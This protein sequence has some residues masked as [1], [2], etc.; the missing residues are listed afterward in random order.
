MIIFMSSSLEHKITTCTLCPR[1]VRWRQ[2]IGRIKVPRFQGD[3]YWAKPVAGFGSL[4]AECL[5]VGLAPA[6]HGANRTGRMFTGDRSGEWLYRALAK[7]GFANQAESHHR[8][9]GLKLHN[10]FITAVLHCAPPQNKPAKDEIT[11]CRR[12]FSSEFRQLKRLR[13][14]ICLGQ[15][16][17]KETLCL[18]ESEFRIKFTPKPKFS[19]GITFKTSRD[20]TIIGSYHPSQKNTFTGKLTEEMFDT[21]FRKAR[22]ILNKSQD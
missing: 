2:D 10:C 9:D 19:H 16:A 18:L 21:V 5:I 3:T 8:K 14:M 22:H 12:F 7:Q 13:V 20:L 17:F 4:Q 6:A 1:L 11:N 15:I